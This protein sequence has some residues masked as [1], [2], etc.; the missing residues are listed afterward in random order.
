M[1]FQTYPLFSVKVTDILHAEIGESEKSIHNL[2]Q[3]ALS[4]QPSVIFI[5]EMDSLFDREEHNES[6]DDLLGKLRLQFV[7]EINLITAI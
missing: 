7:Y 6:E 5:D 3:I 4:S 1:Y 2:F